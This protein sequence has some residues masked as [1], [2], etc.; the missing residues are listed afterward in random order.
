[1]R[2]LISSSIYVRILGSTVLYVPQD[3]IFARSARCVALSAAAAAGSASA[4]PVRRPGVLFGK[5]GRSRFTRLTSIRGE[6]A[7]DISTAA[8]A[9]DVVRRSAGSG[10]AG[11]PVPRFA[12]AH[13]DDGLDQQLRYL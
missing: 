4:A 3:I 13:C 6:V 5:D 2:I 9:A 8:V 10:S 12:R 11:S 1:M 7:K